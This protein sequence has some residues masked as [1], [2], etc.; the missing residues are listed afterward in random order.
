[1]AEYEIFFKES[2]WKDLGKVPKSDLKRI[3]SRIEK[4]GDDPRPIGCE[5][6]T[7]QEL[8]RA[9]QGKYRIV[10][11]IQ[12]NELTVWVIKVDHRKDVYR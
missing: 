3:L 11:P 8:Y 7:G 4:L 10:Y 1:M 9:R 12:E 6:L 5:K 2:V